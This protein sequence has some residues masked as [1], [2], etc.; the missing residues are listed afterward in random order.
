MSKEEF[1]RLIESLPDTVEFDIKE[2]WERDGDKLVQY[3]HFKSTYKLCEVDYINF[4]RH[5]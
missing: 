5:E 1:I 3:A 2:H 4:N